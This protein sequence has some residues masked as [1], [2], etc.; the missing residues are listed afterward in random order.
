MEESWQV[1]FLLI[2]FRNGPH[3]AVCLFLRYYSGLGVKAGLKG[4]RKPSRMYQD[5][6]HHFPCQQALKPATLLETIG[7]AQAIIHFRSSP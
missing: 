2:M 5:E 3:G 4:G 6:R 7:C 1:F